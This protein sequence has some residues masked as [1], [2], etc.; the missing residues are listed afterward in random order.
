LGGSDWDARPLGGASL[1]AI[2][3]W[4]AN[5]RLNY[6][7]NCAAN[8]PSCPGPAVPIWKRSNLDRQP[9]WPPTNMSL[10]GFAAPTEDE[11]HK[12]R[13]EAM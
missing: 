12:R 8:A 4:R 1:N 13:K 10:V 2:S 9:F 7:P 5:E 6:P 3:G 11:S